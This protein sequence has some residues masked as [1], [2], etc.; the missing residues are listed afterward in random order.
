MILLY[1][2]EKF[3]IY[4]QFK[5]QILSSVIAE[6]VKCKAN[7]M[8]IDKMQD[9][10]YGSQRYVHKTFDTYIPTP[11]YRNK[12]KITKIQKRSDYEEFAPPYTIITL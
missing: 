9:L 7:K 12:I 2:E 4:P 10:D 11:F 5:D 3:K 1:I 8:D 6:L